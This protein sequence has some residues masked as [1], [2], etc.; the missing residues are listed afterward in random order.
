MRSSAL[1]LLCTA[2]SLA[3]QSPQRSVRGVVFDSVAGQPLAG[4]V[5]QVALM[6]STAPASRRLFSGVSDSIGRYVVRG[7]VPGRYVIGFQHDALVA[8]GIEAPLRGFDVSGDGVVSVDLG[9]PSPEVLRRVRCGS[10]DPERPGMLSGFVT[11]A[12]TGAL[13]ASGSVEVHWTEIGV[14]D[15]RI[16][17]VPFSVRAD[18]GADGSYLAC[19]LT[20]D[21]MVSIRVAAL[22]QRTL[23]GELV[24]PVSGVLVRDFTMAD[25]AAVSGNGRLSG[26]VLL[27]DG[28]P[29][30][31]GQVLIAALGIESPITNGQFS[32]TGVP[33]GTWLVDARALGY[34]PQ[35]A[36][37][38]VS[39]GSPSSVSIRLKARA[40]VLD[41]VSVVG[42]ANT[43]E[44]S[45]LT[46]IK[47]RSKM[48][49][50]TVFGPGSEA[51]RNALVPADVVR[52]ARGFKYISPT[53]VWGRSQVMTMDEN[54]RRCVDPRCAQ[55]EDVRTRGQSANAEPC[56]TEVD[57]KLIASPLVRKKRLVLYL[58]GMIF[59][60]GLS[61]LNS[62]INMQE[63]LAI[64]AYPDVGNAPPQW[65]TQE[66]CA[67]IA[68]WTKKS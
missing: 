61:M 33:A 66:A 37:A 67:I 31:S 16:T 8:L 27:S 1:L 36:M 11:S 59:N 22:G 65:R 60:G 34:E 13:P 50:G 12:R 2:A 62:T 38:D 49:S 24:I 3:A 17:A 7:L 64:E 42:T 52:Y 18:I 41:A 6:D 53:V 58:D 43:R 5:V 45:V 35:S 10:G 25:T 29:L 55:M 20:T 14:K 63:V 21:A 56:T 54:V 30:E 40:Q 19:N 9:T 23:N 51:L 48:A 39:D 57:D 28:K 46:G 4:A 15:R 68:V 32:L 26:R 44:I 47:E